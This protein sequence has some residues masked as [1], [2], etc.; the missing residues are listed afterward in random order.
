MPPEI[1]AKEEAERKA[2]EELE[3][4]KKAEW[5]ALDEDTKFYRTKEDCFILKSIRKGPVDK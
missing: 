2:K 3:A 5:D 1:K 4:K